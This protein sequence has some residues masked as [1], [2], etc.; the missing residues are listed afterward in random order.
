MNSFKI[1]NN[2]SLS[3]QAKVSIKNYIKQMDLS[4][5]NKLPREEKLA[6]IIG[7]SRVTIRAALNDLAGEGIIFRRQGKGTFVNVDSLNIKVTFSPVIEFT[8]MIKDSGYNPGVKNLN[9]SDY[10]INQDEIKQTL[11]L[12]KND[13]LVA[14]EKMFFADDMV[15]AYSVDI[16]SK[17]LL[18]GCPYSEV[19]NYDKSVFEYIYDQTKREIVWD[20]IDLHVVNAESIPNYSLYLKNIFSKNTPLLL[21]EGVNYD[22][23]DNPLVY[24]KEYINSQI[25]QFSVIR[26]R[27][28]I[29]R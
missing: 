14:V 27:K 3:E 5:S 2:I 1:S 21:L 6:E 22:N 11:L 8:Q 29:Y 20:K 4:K 28:I 26:Q 18:N 9:V 25:I 23:N 13:K 19:L 24:S 17:K 16:F 7:V 10:T 15:C 12:E